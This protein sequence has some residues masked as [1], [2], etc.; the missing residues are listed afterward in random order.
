MAKIDAISVDLISG[1]T[2]GPNPAIV[3]E[4]SNADQPPL[5]EGYLEVN[6]S[7]GGFKW[8]L[9]Y[10]AVSGKYLKQF[11]DLKMEKLKACLDISGI[12]TCVFFGGKGGSGDEQDF[13]YLEVGVD[14]GVVQHSYVA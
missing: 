3:I 2:I 14:D 11:E 6:S 12:K 9:G 4:A 7:A 13:T 5:I 1:R 8:A 10:F